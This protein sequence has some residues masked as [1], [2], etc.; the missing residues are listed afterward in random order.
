MSY[1]FR[2]YFFVGVSLSLTLYVLAGVACAQT[3]KTASVVTSRT[4]KVLAANVPVTIS[5]DVNAGRHPISPL[6]YGL[7][8]PGSAI[9]DLNCPLVRIGGNNTTRYNWQLNAD[10]KGNDYFFESFPDDSATPGERSDTFVAVNKAGGALSM[11]TIPLI[12]WVAKVGNG[13]DPRGRLASFPASKYP[14]QQSFDPYYP[15]GGNGIY[16]STGQPITGNDPNLANMQNSVALQRGWV[17]HLV[18]KWGTAANGGVRYYLMD[19]ESSIWHGSHRDVQPVGASMDAMWDKFRTYGEAIKSVDPSAKI[20]GPEEWGWSGYFYSGRDQQWGPSHGYDFYHA[21]DRSTHGEADYIPWLLSKYADYDKT[22]NKRLLDVLS[23]HIYPQGGEFGNDVSAD[24]QS[25]RNRSTRSLWDP[26]Y[27]D[28]T[29]I[30]DYVQ[31]APRLKGWVAQYYPGTLIGLT[32]YNWGAEGH[33]NGATTQADILGILGREGLDLATRWTTP[34]PGTPA[35]KAISM[36]RNYDGNKSGFGDTSVS[37]AAPDPNTVSAFASQDSAGGAVSIV[38]IAKESSGSTPVTVNVANFG[39]ASSA[40]VWQL[41][42]IGGSA[43]D[44]AITKLTDV[45]VSSAGSISLT[46]PS[47]SVTVLRLDTAT[48]GAG[49]GLKGTYYSG[50]ALTGT[51]VGTRTDSRVAFNWGKSGIPGIGGLGHN[52]FAVRWEG[53]AQAPV[54]GDYSFYTVTASGVRVRVNGATVIEDWTAH[55][56]RLD[57]SVTTVHLTAGQ[58]VP[59][60]MDYYHAT[61]VAS[62]QLYWSYSG[63]T[64]QAIPRANLYPLTP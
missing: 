57:Q 19:N 35:Y 36:F 26:I 14:D 59:L 37:A 6:I 48:V 16:K 10:N 52:N 43:T 13:N 21:P 15:G 3:G 56:P 29:W 11:L 34:N 33:M 9:S 2:S 64:M 25:R 17:Q 4:R 45:P 54:T 23:V 27:K 12:D 53:F 22:N 8:Y 58:R 38:V 5:V 1:H 61:G 41:A 40:R 18:N 49:T 44:T 39:G 42:G 24:M 63:Q 51:S 32:E 46:V 50:T 28:E 47:P 60:A 55:S 20:V 7:C 62:A 31:L 30:A